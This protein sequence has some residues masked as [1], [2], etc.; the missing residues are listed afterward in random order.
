MSNHQ[1]TAIFY[2]GCHRDS[3]KDSKLALR[4]WYFRE[5]FLERSDVYPECGRWV[6]NTNPGAVTS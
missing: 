4:D 3:Q 2:Q 1:I 5:G 6:I